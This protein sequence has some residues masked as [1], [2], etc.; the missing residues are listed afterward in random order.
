MCASFADTVRPVRDH[1]RIHGVLP[2][3]G[4]GLQSAVR[5]LVVCFL[6]LINW[7]LLARNRSVDGRDKTML[8]IVAAGC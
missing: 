2:L 5:S 3:L 4:A 1:P 8:L 6:V 7:A